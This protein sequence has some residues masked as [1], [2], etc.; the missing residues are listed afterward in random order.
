M[1]PLTLS[2]MSL[3]LKRS[4]SLKKLKRNPERQKRRLGWKLR[5]P[6]KWKLSEEKC[7]PRKMHKKLYVWLLKERW[8]NRW[9]S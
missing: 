4:V 7:K 5:T 3:Q 8:K 2:P 1:T 9:P 6:P